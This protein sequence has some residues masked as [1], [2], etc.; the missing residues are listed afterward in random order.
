MHELNCKLG[1]GL[2]IILLSKKDLFVTFVDFFLT[3]QVSIVT[4]DKWVNV[5]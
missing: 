1:V 5:I 4:F 3:K 2:N